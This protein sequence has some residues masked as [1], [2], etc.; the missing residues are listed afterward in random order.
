MRT[1]NLIANHLSLSLDSGGCYLFAIDQEH[2]GCCSFINAVVKYLTRSLDLTMVDLALD[3]SWVIYDGSDDDRLSPFQKSSVCDFSR[4]VEFYMRQFRNSIFI[5]IVVPVS[6]RKNFVPGI[7]KY[8]AAYTASITI[9]RWKL[10]TLYLDIKH[11]EVL[12]SWVP[13]MTN[14]II[15]VIV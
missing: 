8:S 6:G 12:T 9:H 7:N 15:S 10:S 3:Q 2:T 13:T 1:F 4:L 11:N 5:V 14:I